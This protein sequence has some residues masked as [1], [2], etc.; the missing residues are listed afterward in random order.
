MR[1]M[2]TASRHELRLYCSAETEQDPD[3]RCTWHGQELEA[4][5]E[6]YGV[7][8][9]WRHA[10]ANLGANMNSA[11][12]MGSGEYVYLQQDDWCLKHPLDLS[13]GADLLGRHPRIDF[14]R[15][16][17]PDAEEMRPTFIGKVEGWRM[18]DPKGNWPY[19]DDPHLRRR[20]FMEKWGWYFEGGLHGSASGHL[21]EQIAQ[22]NGL[23]VVA[24]KLYYGHLGYV[25]TVVG[26][27]RDG[28]NRRY[29]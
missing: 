5:C 12:A 6:E 28:K 18:I 13:P 9:K 4:L 10:K 1:E 14:V 16:N 23:G 17:W 19:G 27:F 11:M 24:D 21:M 26:D 25:S 7:V 3:P 8:L 29:E 22:Q 20:A 2:M 15:Y